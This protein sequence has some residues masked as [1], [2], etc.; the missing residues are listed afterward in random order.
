L[1]Q[2]VTKGIVL[3][4]TEFGEA[5]RIITVLTIDHGKIRLI[6]KGVRRIKSK[7]AGGI[8]LFSVS[9]I[10]YIP[11]RGEIGTLISARLIKHYSSIVHDIDRTMYGYEVL[12]NINKVTED[13]AGEEY[14]NLLN[15]ALAAI[16]DS[17]IRLECIRLWFG[18]RLLNTTGHSPNLH[19]DRSGDNLV[20]GAKFD[21][22]FEDMTFAV[23]GNYSSDHIKLLRLAISL[24]TPKALSSVKDIDIVLPDCLFLVQSM[25]AQHIRI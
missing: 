11:G 1:N 13:L 10:T 7:S 8:E 4:R 20:T 24:N 25:V 5:D 2:V 19:S 21:F 6:A 9:D 12:K 23:S 15:T 18:L 16:N 14:F 3:S 17:S 22:N